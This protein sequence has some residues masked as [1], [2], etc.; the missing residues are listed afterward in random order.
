MN[1]KSSDSYLEIAK[2]TNIKCQSLALFWES[3][4][5]LP[6]DL[7]AQ[8]LIKGFTMFYHE[9]RLQYFTHHQNLMQLYAKIQELTVFGEM[10]VMMQYLFQG[11]NRGPAKYKDMLLDIGTEE[12]GHVETS[13]DGCLSTG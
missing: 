11:W 1:R 4:F 12:I 7:E 5:W 3:M 8:Y 2:D 13:H 6:S 10:T 9:K